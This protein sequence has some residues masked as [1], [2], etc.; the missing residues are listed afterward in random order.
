MVTEALAR[1]ASGLDTPGT[2]PTGP[3]EAAAADTPVAAA[4]STL[5]ERSD[6]AIGGAARCVGDLRQAL[7][8]AGDAY[9]IAEESA[10]ASLGGHS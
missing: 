4:W 9:R 3:W 8:L 2:A 7:R 1:A 6:R 10:A 5:V